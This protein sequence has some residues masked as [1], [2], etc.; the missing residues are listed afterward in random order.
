MP[1]L[2]LFAAGL[3]ALVVPVLGPRAAPSPGPSLALVGGTLID[4]TGAPPVADGVLLVEGDRIR[5]AGARSGIALPAEARLVDVAGAF[6]LPG[7]INAHV[8]DAYDDE[9]LAA[10]A[11]AGVTTVRDEA[12]PGSA[13]LAEALALRDRLASSPRHA[14]LVSAGYM[15]TVPG[16]YGGLAVSSPEQAREKVLWELDSGTDLVKVALETGYGARRDLPVL[17]DEELRAAVAAAHERGRLVSAH[18]TVARFLAQVVAAGVDDAAHVPADAVPDAVIRQMVGSGVHLV[19]TL[20]VLEAYGALAG[21][22]SNLRRMAA[23]GVVIALGNDYTLVPQ[24]GFD[25]FELG[26]PMHEIRRMREAGMT[27]AQILAAAT[28]DAA[29]VCG[30]DAALGTLEAG[31]I[32]DVLVV[33]RDPLQDLEALTAVRLVLRGGEVIRAEGVGAR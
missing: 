28:R 30:L 23:A 17:S 6:V 27:P 13:S 29:H 24:N 33:G 1:R 25:H 2:R 4:G 32:A 11:Q 14:R 12:I 3:V 31:K 10:W 20:T 26:M 22:S 15:I 7:F 16:G 19:P 9:R 21:A 5:A 8:H 18:V